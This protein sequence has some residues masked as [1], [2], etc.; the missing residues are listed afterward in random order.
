MITPNE[1]RSA[2]RERGICQKDEKDHYP[3]LPRRDIKAA[4]ELSERTKNRDVLSVYL[5]PLSL[6]PPPAFSA[7]F[8]YAI[9]TP[10]YIRSMSRSLTP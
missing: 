8:V 10:S 2:L 9:T 5:R 1:M 6:G 4:E 3:V 7:F